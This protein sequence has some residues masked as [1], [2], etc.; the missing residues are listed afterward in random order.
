MNPRYASSGQLVYAQGGN[1]MAVPFDPERLEVTGAANS[2]AEGVL[3]SPVSGAV[4]YSFSATGSLVYVPGAIYSAQSRLVWVSRNGTGQ[5]LAA[6]LRAYQFPRISPDGRRLAVGISGQ[7]SQTWLYDFTRDTLTPFTFEG[8]VNQ[9]AN[10]TPDGK[11]IAFQS[12]RE[13]SLNHF[14]QL[15]DGSGGLERLTTGD[16]TQAANSWSPDGQWLAFV[17]VNPVTGYDIWV[18]RLGDRNAQPFIQT[19]GNES[20]PRFSPDGH[21]LAYISDDSGTREVYV[22]PFPG[23]GG[24]YQISTEGGTEPVWNPK[25]RELFYRSGDKMMVVDVTTQPTF[26]VGKPK[27]LFQGSYEATPATFPYDDVS[28]D[29]QRFLML[30]AADQEQLAPTQINVVLNWF[31]ELKQKVSTGKK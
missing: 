29:G 3:Q 2:V 1:L 28:P 27:V 23:P 9:N 20:A 18:L 22:Q 24:K 11:R 5:P 16:Y 10:W 21:W 31:E 25:G 4:Q 19:P 15:A 7:D 26:S 17:E 13:G 8:T 14:W 30:Q 6:P 12:N